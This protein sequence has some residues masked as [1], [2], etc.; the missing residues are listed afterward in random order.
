MGRGG[1]WERGDELSP[2]VIHRRL[3]SVSYRRTVDTGEREKTPRKDSR[4][5]V[6][7]TTGPYNASF[8]LL[9]PPRPHPSLAALFPLN[10][11]CGRDTASVSAGLAGS[12]FVPF[13]SVSWL[14]SLEQ[15][16]RERKRNRKREQ[17]VA[18]GL[19]ADYKRAVF[20][21]SS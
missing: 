19:S 18:A 1:S 13:C 8:P 10:L 4:K 20:A 6:L 11:F 16:G 3:R 9:S 15:G 21:K 17:S 14:E 2:V 7:R 12:S 5:H